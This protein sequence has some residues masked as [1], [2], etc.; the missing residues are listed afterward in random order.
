MKK[1]NLSLVM[2]AL[3][4]TSVQSMAGV[5]PSTNYDG[6]FETDDGRVEI[7]GPKFTEGEGIYYVSVSSNFDGLCK[8]YGYRK[9]V[10][11]SH[12]VNS[13]SYVGTALITVEG[14]FS[15]VIKYDGYYDNRAVGSF[16]C[17]TD[18]RVT[19][20]QR[21][22]KFPV[23]NDDGSVTIIGPSFGYGFG[24]ERR[25]SNSSDHH[26]VCKLYGFGPA[27]TATYSVA[28][29]DLVILNANS[30]F[31]AYQ[32]MDNYY[33]Y[34]FISTITCKSDSVVPF[35]PKPKHQRKRDINYL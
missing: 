11:R 32:L 5:A 26:G 25:F 6:K 23:T 20:S 13:K 22:D 31:A 21:Y 18:N 33:D 17:E 30:K 15:R 7:V 29:N 16:M 28:K 2:T 34:S 3:L 4:L 35:T 12:Y 8:L 24:K 9:A 27:V 14:T 19:Y 10:P 1:L